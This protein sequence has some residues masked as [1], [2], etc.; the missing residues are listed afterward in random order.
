MAGL[1]V[2]VADAADV[3][4]DD[5]GRRGSHGL[6]GGEVAEEGWRYLIDTAVC[7]LRAE[8]DGHE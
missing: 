7:A 5:F 6:G 1:G 3:L 2:G 8:D 4:V